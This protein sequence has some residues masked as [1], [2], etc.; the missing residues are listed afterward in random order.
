MVKI[1]QSPSEL[2]AEVRRAVDLFPILLVPF[3]AG[4]FWLD[5]LNIVGAQ[6]VKRGVS[7]LP[8]SE[9]NSLAVKL[10]V[11]TDTSAQHLNSLILVHLS[12]RCNNASADDTP[13]SNAE[14]KT[15]NG[16]QEDA[17]DEVALLKEQLAAV[18]A[19]NQEL[20]R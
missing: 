7:Q 3:V 1:E 2:S 15:Q 19:E 17:Q 18:L 11:S 5:I 20:E 12:S 6:A 10:G 4:L 13:P 9:R 8:L 14:D 16:A